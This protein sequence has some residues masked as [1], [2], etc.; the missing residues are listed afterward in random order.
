MGQFYAAP[1]TESVTPTASGRLALIRIRF[2]AVAQL[3]DCHQTGGCHHPMW[4]RGVDRAGFVEMYWLMKSGRSVASVRNRR[5][6]SLPFPHPEEGAV[7]EPHDVAIPG[8][9]LFLNV[10]G[11]NGIPRAQSALLCSFAKYI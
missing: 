1:V 2:E 7:Q 8:C 6:P 10:P 5:L 3:L 11:G 4:G 9:D